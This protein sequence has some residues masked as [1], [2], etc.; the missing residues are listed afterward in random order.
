MVSIEKAA[1]GIAAYAAEELIPAL[2]TD[3]KKFAGY[4]VLGSIKS[5]PAAA[6]KPYEP[7][8]RMAGIMTDEG[9]DE[10]VLEDSLMCAF[11]KIPEVEFLGFNFNKG[12]VHKLVSRMTNGG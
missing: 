5:N 6:L 1:D 10:D 11:G 2:P 3:A 9:I 4:I 12:D 7:F 8:L